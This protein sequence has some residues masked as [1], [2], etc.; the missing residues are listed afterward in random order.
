MLGVGVKKKKQNISAKK[1]KKQPLKNMF[2]PKKIPQTGAKCN[3]NQ[4]FGSI[5]KAT[6]IAVGRTHTQRDPQSGG[7][8]TNTLFTYLFG[9]F[10]KTTGFRA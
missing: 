10:F 6:K 7:A 1:K 4:V 9:F 5:A 8:D 3:Q 2:K